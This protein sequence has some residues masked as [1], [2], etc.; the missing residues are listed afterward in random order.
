MRTFFGLC[1]MFMLFLGI[2]QVLF[3]GRYR[4]ELWQNAK[5]QGQSFRLQTER[6]LKSFGL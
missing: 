6:W 5:Y 1:L 4:D 3:A 2:D